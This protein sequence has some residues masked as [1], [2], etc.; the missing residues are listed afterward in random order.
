MHI[1]FS[2]KLQ[3]FFHMINMVKVISYKWNMCDLS[4]SPLRNCKK[5]I[6]LFMPRISRKQ[7]TVSECDTVFKSA[8][9]TGWQIIKI[10]FLLFPFL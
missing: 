3:G 1:E 10:D 7:T 6:F 2:T 5:L 9:S 4:F 8:E